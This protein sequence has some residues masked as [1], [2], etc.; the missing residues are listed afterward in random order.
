MG[1]RMDMGL[2]IHSAFVAG[3]IGGVL[4]SLIADEV[5]ISVML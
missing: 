5:V 3:Q 4:A 2:E 1:L